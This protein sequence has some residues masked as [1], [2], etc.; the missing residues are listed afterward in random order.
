MVFQPDLNKPAA[1][2][3]R[4]LLWTLFN[5]KTLP[6]AVPSDGVVSF[7]IDPAAIDARFYQAVGYPVFGPR[8]IRIDML[9]RVISAVY[10]SADAGKF[11]AQ[12]KMAEWLG[13]P[14]DDL[15][16]VLTAMGHTKI[17]DPA[18]Q[19]KPEEAPATEPV[20][21][22][23]S[24]TKPA[25]QVKP[26]LATFRLK[27]GKAFQKPVE[28]KP[29]PRPEHKEKTKDRRPDKKTFK[30]PKPEEREMRVMSANAK[31]KPEDSPFA[32]LQQLKVKK[33]GA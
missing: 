31:T 25:V 5:D 27:K 3:L 26:E 10:D 23:A 28:H 2:H 12:H 21:E 13:C 14:I 19:P 6:A 15:Y 32:V 29:R 33:D 1:V 18:D 4:A 9:D 20:A 17:H 30:R 11:K 7:K 22:V 8:A 24:E 16:Q